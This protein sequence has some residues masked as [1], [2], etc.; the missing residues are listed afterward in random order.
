VLP[1]KSIVKPAPGDGSSATLHRGLGA[2]QATALNIANMVGIGP[3]IT[4]PAFLAAMYGPQALIAWVIAAV[5]VLCDGLVWSELGAALPGS[6]GSYHF[7]SQVYGRLRFGRIVPFLFIWQFLVSGTLEM[8]SGYIAGVEYLKYPFPGLEDTL[9]EWSIPGGERSL[10]A[11]AVLVVTVILCRHI[12]SIGW[13]GIVLCAGTIITLL[14]VIISGYS[15]FD[16]GLLR[17]PDDAFRLSGRHPFV[18]GL[19]AAMAIAIYDYLGYYNICHLG[20]E[21]VDPGRTIPRA[22]MTSIVVVAILYLTMNLAIIGVIPWEKAMHSQYIASEFMEVIYGR[23]AAELFT[24]LILWTVAASVFA[25]TLGYSRIPYVAARTGG[26]FRVFAIVHPVHR[27]PVVSLAAL[28]LLTAVFCYFPLEEVIKAAVT[29]RI[30]VQFIGQIVGLHIL[31][32]TRPEVPLPFRMWLYPLPSLVAC[33]GWIF[34]FVTSDRQILYIAV[35]VLASGCAAF[36]AWNASEALMRSPPTEILSGRRRGG[37]AG[38]ARLALHAAAFFYGLAIRVRNSVYDFGW[39]A[40]ERASLPVVS[41]GN[42]TTGGTGK[43]PLA[44]FVARWYRERGVRVCFISRGYGAGAGGTNDEALVLDQLCPDVPHLQDADRA[45]AARVAAEELDS[46]LLILDDGFQHR[47]LARDL[48]I[49]L[50]DATNPWGFCHLLPR[51]LLR[52]PVSSLARATFVVITRVDLASREEVDALR[53]RISQ[54]NPRCEL[55]EAVFAPLR[56]IGSSGETAS[57]KSLAGA[58]VAAFCGIGNPEAFR[59]SLG[60][61]GWNI[62]AFRVFPDHYSF[63]RSDVED[64]DRWSDGLAVDAVVCTQK[65][66]V[67]IALERLGSHRLWALEI[68]T[69]VVAGAEL[70][71]THL[72]HALTR[73]HPGAAGA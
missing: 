29:V 63:T 7:L 39:K 70:L 72:E 36:A 45:A 41:L 4:I 40:T 14:T 22:V 9:K 69:Q 67:K 56:L 30:L 48:D 24:W 44:A 13:L 34:V 71:S 21:V 73:D 59:S 61:L 19:G 17:L 8:A 32:T 43:T 1:W 47:R 57:L 25:L 49:V 27:Y 38:A 64:L 68:G 62:A 16:P 51:G 65:D 46:Q 58:R 31:R 28:G 18:G 60:H 37:L 20:E 23:R 6:G 54:A 11:A 53:R 66:L 12:R 10:A 33:C 55:A 50:I 42:L 2:V 5:L 3:F 26:F 35:G 15:H 52:E